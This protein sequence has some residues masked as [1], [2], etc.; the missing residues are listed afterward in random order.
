MFRALLL[1]PSS[2]FSPGLRVP[3]SPSKDSSK[4]PTRHSRRVTRRIRSAG[5][6]IQAIQM[7]PIQVTKNHHSANNNSN[8]NSSGCPISEPR[9][10]NLLERNI[11]I[12]I[13]RK[14]TIAEAV[15]GNLRSLSN[16]DR[17]SFQ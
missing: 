4:E 14:R 2:P 9:L 13:Q 12:S 8:K 7:R 15:Q 5:L 17:V 10:T 6:D 16:V 3:G 1:S 11:P